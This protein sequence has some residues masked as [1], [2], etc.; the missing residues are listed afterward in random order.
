MYDMLGHLG[1]GQLS[2]VNSVRV[3]VVNLYEVLNG[4]REHY[5]VSGS[6][7]CIVTVREDTALIENGFGEFE[8][9]TIPSGEIIRLMEGW[10]Q[11]LSAYENG[12]IPGIIPENKKDEWVIVPKAFVK[13]TY[14]Q[15]PE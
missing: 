5:I 7:W 9:L 15:D 3:A 6:D 14:W 12:K 10:L 4:T 1:C 2:E 13:D 8:P 11:F